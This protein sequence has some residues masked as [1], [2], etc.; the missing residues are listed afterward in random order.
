MDSWIADFNFFTLDSSSSTCSS[1]Y[2]CKPEKFHLP[3]RL[4]FN[5][6]SS[7]L[8]EE[9]IGLDNA[10]TIKSHLND[11]RIMRLFAK[12]RKSLS[13]P[14]FQKLFL[15]DRIFNRKVTFFRKGHPNMGIVPF[16]P[17]R[18]WIWKRLHDPIFHRP[19][20]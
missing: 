15:F 3:C 1:K 13:T 6:Q 16:V 17:L 19:L 12:E 5:M 4:Y 2:S 9:V 8:F 20:D 10:S 7:K 18:F 14:L 11:K